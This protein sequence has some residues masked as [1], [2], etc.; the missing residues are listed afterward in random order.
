MA[1]IDPGFQEEEQHLEID[2]KVIRD[3]INYKKQMVQEYSR[4]IKNNPGGNANNIQTI[5]RLKAQRDTLESDI[6]S[7]TKWSMCPYI[8]RLDF[9]DDTQSEEET[10]YIGNERIEL[11][12]KT[13]AISWKA[14]IAGLYYDNEPK[15]YELS[16]KGYINHYT[17][18]LKR[19]LD[20][21]N[22][23][24]EKCFTVF[25]ENAVTLDGKVID[26]KLLE[27]LK[28]KRDN[29]KLTD[30]IR[31]IQS[32][33]NKIMRSPVD[34]SFILQGCAGSGKTMILLHRIAVVL[35][36]N[37]SIMPQNILVLTPNKNFNTFIDELSSQLGLKDVERISIDEYYKVLLERYNSNQKIDG[38]VISETHLPEELLL[39]LY[40]LEFQDKVISNYHNY[41]NKVLS[42]IKGS[43]FI[44]LCD[45]LGTTKPQLNTHDKNCLNNLEGMVSSAK[46]R[47]ETNLS[48]KKK[49]EERIRD[50]KSRIVVGE[51]KCERLSSEIEAIREK[52]LKTIT[53]ELDAISKDISFFNDSLKAHEQNVA[54]SLKERNKLDEKLWGLRN[55]LLKAGSQPAAVLNYDYVITSDTSICNKLKSVFAKEIAS[56]R[57][58]KAN[59]EKIPSYAFARRNKVQGELQKAIS[60]FENKCK[61]YIKD[62]LELKEEINKL[63]LE[64]EA[65]DKSI[66]DAQKD[67]D[68]NKELLKPYLKRQEVLGYC[69]TILSALLY[70]G[71]SSV[72]AEVYS[73]APDFMKEYDRLHVLLR[74]EKKGIATNK[75]AMAKDNE[76]LA[77]LTAAGILPDDLNIVDEAK[78]QID[79]LSIKA[80]ER[81][82]LL[83]GILD[84]YKSFGVTYKKDSYRYRLYLML[85]LDSLFYGKTL[86][87]HTFIS[88]D[89]AQD[90]S[91]AE[92]KM[93]KS[94]FSDKA[95]FNLYGDVNQS[96]YP[97]KCIEEWEKLVP[98]FGDNIHVLNENYRNPAPITD[99]INKRFD[100]GIVS[101]GL[102]G[103]AVKEM[104]LSDALTSV[105][106]YKR[107]LPE[108]RCAIITA[109][110]D[111]DMPAS[112][113]EELGAY[114][115][116]FSGVID[117]AVIS[118][119][120]VEAIKGLEFEYVVAVVD[121]MSI[122]EE[123][124]AYSRALAKLVVVKDRF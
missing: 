91:F 45:K 3:E 113:R 81:E 87:R 99:Y 19:T 80:L 44:A 118:V 26:K 123:Y 48:E 53:E 112:L 96:L 83:P 76:E 110:D 24:L 55:A 38:E 65:L 78:K 36:N 85:L 104:N 15:S 58:L 21:K 11:D 109:F 115:L 13:I 12:N 32:N 35:Y 66:A 121:G 108:Y 122:N 107:E 72:P 124:I 74:N 69:K 29:P 33:Q 60:D 7:L 18:T 70:T 82:T 90:I 117:D 41:W 61:N 9:K 34:E 62:N 93:L 4:K 68:K 8:G 103:E 49:Y 105:V 54:N 51:E 94:I 56:I 37:K 57:L 14:P 40:S 100:T 88:I 119:S 116:H 2:Q 43:S 79:T 6:K 63:S 71:F 120:N 31:T 98:L 27:I 25:G 101:I 46:L 84:A 111:I 97:H 92:Y 23:K 50:L 64:K 28:E 42:N 77:K 106:R 59:I 73:K 1:E 75:A 95:V 39:R 67:A 22:G 102:E 10:I 20:I 86:L 47:I 114:S 30:I 16:V 52:G 5:Q 89:E 17:V